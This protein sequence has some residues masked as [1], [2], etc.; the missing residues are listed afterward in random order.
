MKF[1]SFSLWGDNPLYTVG[2]IKNA[3]LMN[4]IYPDW[5]MVVY[6]D[7]TSPKE[8]IDKLNSFG[9]ITIDATEYGVYGMFWRFYASDLKDCERVIF[10]DADSRISIREK[11]A[12][13][14]WISDDTVIHVMRDHPGH[15][16]P[17]GNNEPGIL[18]GMWGIKGNVIPMQEMI[19]KFCGG[20]I[21]P[22]GSDQTFLRNIYRAF[23]NN[24]TTHDPFFEKKDF[25]TQRKGYRFIGERINPDGTPTTD[26]WV[27][28]KNYH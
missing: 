6:Y 4:V 25:P 19:N 5:K 11:M 17:Y 27:T 13:D 23:I 22:Y 2:I 8:V 16:I 15:I 10:R 12:V 14:E 28:L 21:L 1:V 26:D 7:N 9:V 18:G 3:E 20:K 24:K